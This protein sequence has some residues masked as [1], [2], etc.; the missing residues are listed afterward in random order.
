MTLRDIKSYLAWDMALALFLAMLLGKVV[1]L[2]GN[3]EK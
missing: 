1:I 2:F 3:V